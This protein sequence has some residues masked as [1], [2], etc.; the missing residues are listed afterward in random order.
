MI[1]QITPNVVSLASKTTTKEEWIFRIAIVAGLALTLI[2]VSYC[3]RKSNSKTYT[4]TPIRTEKSRSD[5]VASESA[6]ASQVKQILDAC[7]TGNIDD[8][9]QVLSN[10]SDVN[11]FLTTDDLGRQAVYDACAAGSAACIQE[12]INRVSDPNT[13]LGPLLNQQTGLHP[14]CCK[15]H[16]ECVKL[17]LQNGSEITKDINTGWTPL[18]Y[19]C[20]HGHIDC[21]KA[22][23]EG[24]T[25]MESLVNAKTRTGETAL[26]LAS[27]NNQIESVALLLEIDELSILKNDD[28]ETALHYAC[29]AGRSDVVATLIAST[30]FDDLNIEDNDGYT[31]LHT[32]C[33]EGHVNCIETILQTAPDLIAVKDAQGNTPLHLAVAG[34]CSECVKTVLEHSDDP[35]GLI[36]E[37]NSKGDTP[38]HIACRQMDSTTTLDLL[39]AD[40]TWEHSTSESHTRN[41]AEEL[42]KFIKSKD[43]FEMKDKSG[44]TPLELSKLYLYKDEAENP[45]RQKYLSLHGA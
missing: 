35:E 29:K 8:L 45:V 30:F 25:N 19:A 42:L 16:I 4:Y 39:L 2:A 38:L 26:H 41:T 9:K 10:I 21:A 1:T 44:C 43:I 7:L 11:T 22:L 24:S 40:G 28:G 3:C 32:A 12:L 37:V 13:I 17:L 14:A 33:S 31:A 6:E 15:G 20:K 18:H 23:I 27:V 34:A 36:R 5:S